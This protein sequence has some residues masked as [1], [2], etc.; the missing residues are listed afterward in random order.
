MEEKNIFQ[1]TVKSLLSTNGQKSDRAPW[2]MNLLPTLAELWSYDSAI[3]VNFS[4]SSMAPNKALDATQ[5]EYEKVSK[6]QI[7]TLHCPKGPNQ[8]KPQMFGLFKGRIAPLPDKSN[9]YSKPKP[10]I[11]FL[12]NSPSQDVIRKTLTT[13]CPSSG[14][15]LLVWHLPMIINHF[16]V[17]RH[18]FIAY[19]LLVSICAVFQ[20]CHTGRFDEINVWPRVAAH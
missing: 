3:S 20:G 10:Q 13:V 6:W 9:P 17:K 11:S 18:S 14:S 19:L 5:K 7:W 1:S 8:T 4:N 15:S 12:Y 2:K 16:F